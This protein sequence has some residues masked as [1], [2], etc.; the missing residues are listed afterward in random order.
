MLIVFGIACHFNVTHIVLIMYLNVK[1]WHE[2]FFFHNCIYFTVT[3]AYT[4][5]MMRF[6]KK[7]VEF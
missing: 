2:D 3:F 4:K 5:V 1:D 7:K 6:L